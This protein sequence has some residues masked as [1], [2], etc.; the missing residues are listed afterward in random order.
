MRLR[1]SAWLL[2]SILAL[3]LLPACS[4]VPSAENCVEVWN[5][6]L[7]SP[8]APALPAGF[9]H[10]VVYGWDDKADEQGCAIVLI[11]RDGGPWTSF[12]RVIKPESADASW[13]S[14]SGTRWGQD[15]PEGETPTGFNATVA[16]DG[17]V[18][19]I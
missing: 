19:L 17:S 10:A 12:A 7:A 5:T 6:A 4:N 13:A 16:A 9:R 3:M 2:E 15:N 11:K 8:D 18:R 1:R 14:V